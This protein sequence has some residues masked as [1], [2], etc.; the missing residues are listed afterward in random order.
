MQIRPSSEPRRHLGTK[1]WSI[2]ISQ[3]ILFL[4]KKESPTEKYE[5][6]RI[7][8]ENRRLVFRA[9]AN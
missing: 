3:L 7:F 5:G 1:Y 8:Q 4:S 9:P 2:F 6:L